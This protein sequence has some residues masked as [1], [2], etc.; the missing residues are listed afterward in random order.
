MG[1]PCPGIPCENELLPR[2]AG[3]KTARQRPQLSKAGAGRSQTVGHHAAL[4]SQPAARPGNS[5]VRPHLR[6]A[7]ESRPIRGGRLTT[8]QCLPP[9]RFWLLDEE[10]LYVRRRS[11][12]RKAWVETRSC[13]H[14]TSGHRVALLAEG[15]G[16]ALFE[17]VKNGEKPSSPLFAQT[18]RREALPL[19]FLLALPNILTPPAF[20]CRPRSPG[21]TGSY[22]RSCTGTSAGSRSPPARAPGGK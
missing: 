1:R 8:V 2:K 3:R 16:R 15:N 17:P 20:S 11:P 14:H 6:Q 19:P 9:G 5:R 10:K 13:W 22:A 21:T 12:L 7:G 18:K 4:F